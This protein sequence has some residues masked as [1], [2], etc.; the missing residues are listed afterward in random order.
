MITLKETAAI[1]AAPGMVSTQ[2]TAI[3]PATPQRTADN[4]L[5]EPTPRMEA[6]MTW[7]VLIG[8]PKKE[9]VKITPAA[10]VSAEK[11]WTAW[12]WKILWPMVLIIRQPPVAVPRPMHRAQ[13][14][15]TQTGT[16]IAGILW[17]MKRA[18]VMRPMVF[19][20]SFVPWLTD[21]KAEESI[22][23]LLKALFIFRGC[24]SRKIQERASIMR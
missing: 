12:R 8:A 21:M 7:V 15:C 22:W 6:E 9:A 17:L 19:C 5:D 16:V 20:A 18:R 2:A 1:S 10:D 3:C 13:E 11:P 23:S 14:I 24:A 4:R